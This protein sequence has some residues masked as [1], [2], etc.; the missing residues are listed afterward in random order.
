MPTPILKV[1]T[2]YCSVYVDDI[3]LSSL[4][5]EDMPLYARRMWGYFRPAISLFSIPSDMQMYLVGTET[6]PK[7]IEPVFLSYQYT[8]TEDTTED[9]T[10]DLGTDYEG[11]ELFCCRIRTV[12]DFGNII[13]S[14]TD[15]ATYNAELGTLTFTASESAPIAAGTVYEMDFYTDGQFE[16]ALSHEMM[17]I[18]GMCFQCIWQD[19]FNTDWLSMVAKIEDRSFTEQN[20]AN[21]VRADTER[22]YSL[23]AKLAGEMRRFEQNLAF[24]KEFPTGSGLI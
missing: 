5:A 20:R 21:K 18:L 15:N 16:K 22:L 4:A 6:N 3:N 10:V 9:T 13:M 12:D 14:S 23:R 2:E 11:F 17:N 8:F 7:L 24:R 1:I 19:R